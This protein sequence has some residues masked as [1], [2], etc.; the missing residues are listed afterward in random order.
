MGLS[1]IGMGYVAYV[2]IFEKGSVD[3]ASACPIDHK[4]RQEMVDL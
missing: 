2:Q 3:Q 4:S 1:M